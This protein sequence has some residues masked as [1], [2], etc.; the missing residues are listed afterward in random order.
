METLSIPTQVILAI[1][2]PT[3]LVVLFTRITF[4][5]YVALL[6]TVALFAASV[7][8]GYTHRWW[9]YI[10]DAASLT[11]GFWYAGYMMER[12]KKSAS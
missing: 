9:I 6:L 3:L 1:I 5:R 2:A 10:L 4:N 11:F 12:N 7:Y 8:A